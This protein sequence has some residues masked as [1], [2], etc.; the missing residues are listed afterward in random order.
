[1]ALLA[2]LRDVQLL[3]CARGQA[4]TISALQDF[5]R[6]TENYLFTPRTVDQQTWSSTHTTKFRYILP[7]TP[8]AQMCNVCSSHTRSHRYHN[9]YGSGFFPGNYHYLNSEF[10]N[11]H[12]H[13]V[14]LLLPRPGR[15]TCQTPP[16]NSSSER[17]YPN[18]GSQCTP[19]MVARPSPSDCTHI[20]SK[21]QSCRMA[22]IQQLSTA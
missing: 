22:R 19:C 8:Q 21:P 7:N 5:A 15:A 1:M 6:N 3:N 20:N 14:Q 16:H 18:G 13:L 17:M 11:Y 12:L 4:T 9:I 10:K 2:S